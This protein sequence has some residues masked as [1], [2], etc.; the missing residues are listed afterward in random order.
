MTKFFGKTCPICG[1]E[2]VTKG[3]KIVGYLVKMDS[4]KRKEKR[5]KRKKIL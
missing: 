1:E 3:I 5:V 2:S 4:F